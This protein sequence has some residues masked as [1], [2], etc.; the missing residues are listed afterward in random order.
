[1]TNN[2]GSPSRIGH[3][4][5]APLALPLCLAKLAHDLASQVVAVRERS[6]ALELGLSLGL[7]LLLPHGIRHLKSLRRAPQ[8]PDY[9]RTYKGKLKQCEEQ[10]CDCHLAC[11]H[12]ELGYGVWC[13][14]VFP[15]FRMSE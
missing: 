11:R 4:A 2:D 14:E 3:A 1:M 10:Q 5:Q 6:L 13:A 7:V 15:S 12:V 8:V 9:L